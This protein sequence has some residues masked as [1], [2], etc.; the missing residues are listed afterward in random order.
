MKIL[1]VI[2]AYN[3][4]DNI[5]ELINN[6]KKIGIENLDILVVND[7]SS[8]KTQLMCSELRVDIIN[9]PCNLGIGGAVQTGYKF[10]HNNDYD[11]AIQVDGDGQH[12]PEYIEKLLQPI[13]ER[14]VDLVIG[15]R[16][17][18]KEGFQSTFLR[19]VGINYFSKLLFTLTGQLITD[20]TSGFRACN[21][22]VIEIFSKRY[23]VDYPEPE[24][25]MYLKRNMYVIEE[26][27]V[28][29]KSRGSGTSSITP[30]KSMYY[31]LKVS[32]AIMI[33]KLRRE[34]V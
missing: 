22:R 32:M 5:V 8:D 12:R 16:Y 25:I 30:F 18:K 20:P 23:P 1:L 26:I 31:M 27:P 10:A 2:P 29:M 28:V 11:I 21:K 17:I 33:D 19:R 9:L 13:I 7:C 34:T 3:E 4:Q 15:S 6:I 24:S 14:N